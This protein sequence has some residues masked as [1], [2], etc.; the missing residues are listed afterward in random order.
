[1]S[2]DERRERSHT[3]WKTRKTMKRG[4]LQGVTEA[5]QCRWAFHCP[6]DGEVGTD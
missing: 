6:G 2:K 3:D 5:K 1:M 4:K